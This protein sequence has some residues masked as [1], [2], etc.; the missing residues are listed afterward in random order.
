MRYPAKSHPLPGRGPASVKILAPAAFALLLAL[1]LLACR[2][3]PALA[4]P[5]R[6]EGVIET[7]RQDFGDTEANVIKRNGQPTARKVRTEKSVHDGHAFQIVTLVYAPME[8]D[9][10]KDSVYK[11]E[12]LFGIRITKP[13]KC[14]IEGVCVGGPAS[15]AVATLGPPGSKDRNTLTWNDEIDAYDLSIT[16][17]GH[18][19]IQFVD[20]SII[21]D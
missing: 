21:F 3:L 15:V 14:L 20:F 4:Q 7:L 13:G 11:T 16:Q 2:A 17:N 18:G 10:F 8:I 6:V 1:A 19:V 9:V 5:P 12:T